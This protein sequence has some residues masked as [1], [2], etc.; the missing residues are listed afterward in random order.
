MADF[1]LILLASAMGEARTRRANVTNIS[2]ATRD[3]TGKVI[4]KTGRKLWLSQSSCDRERSK[5]SKN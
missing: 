3:L 5:S 1:Q 4:N 2:K